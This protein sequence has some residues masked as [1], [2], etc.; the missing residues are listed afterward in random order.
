MQI[1][2]KITIDLAKRG[3]IETVDAM[4]GDSNTR[5]VEITLLDNGVAWLPSDATPSVAF[6][7][8]D[9]KSGWYDTLPDGSAA[10]N[11]SDHAVTAILAPQV[12]S[13]PGRVSAAVVFQD[14]DLNQLATFAF[15]IIVE[16]NPAAGSVISNDYYNLQTMEQINVAIDELWAA[17][18]SAG[19]VDDSRVGPNA[20]SSKNTV[21]KLCPAF[22]ESG[23]KV[24]C[25][26]VE[27]YPLSVVS[28][29]VPTQGGS[30]DPSPDNVRPLLPRSGANLF[31]GT[32]KAEPVNVYDPESAIKYTAFLRAA[33][34]LWMPSSDS[35]STRVAC[36]PMTTYIV[37]SG[38]TQN[39]LVRIAWT[40]S[41]KIPVSAP[42]YEP[43]SVYD[44]QQ[45]SENAELTI[46]T[47]ATAKYLI[48]QAGAGTWEDTNL[49]MTVL[50]TSPVV[51]EFAADFGQEVYGG[52][53]DWNTGV[54]TIDTVKKSFDGTET[55]WTTTSDGDNFGGAGFTMYRAAIKPQ[56]VRVI[57]PDA[58]CSHFPTTTERLNLKE[59]CYRQEDHAENC[60]R[61]AVPIECA[62][63]KTVAEWKTWL[64]SQAS[65]GTPLAITYKVTDPT[66]VQLEPHE[67]HA[68]AGMNNLYTDTGDTAVSGRAD[69]NAVIADIYEKL[70]AVLATTAALTG[71]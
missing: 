69:P 21:D 10:C 46:T 45:T 49:T 15:T 23:T 59:P 60:L 3:I 5:A 22:T 19:G 51:R 57:N 66:V 71:V 65:A 25:E 55:Y 42:N 44:L 40:D 58:V 30:S 1:T 48:I 31:L 11:I 37:N 27:G 16:E 63:N 17:I 54:L 38:N 34:N 8:P 68:L 32:S 6:K 61:F 56:P 43:V 64:A 18:D 70:N 29:I 7:K 2:K 36:R 14:A 39:K 41:D 26:P 62:P 28:Q 53:L 20:W 4:Q 47:G 67:I 35:A 33:D 50:E 24:T 9:G 52:S 13:A 12:L